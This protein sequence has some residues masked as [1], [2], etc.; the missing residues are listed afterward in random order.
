MDG[1]GGYGCSYRRNALEKC[2]GAQEL[3]RHIHHAAQT[4]V[5]EY[6]LD[7]YALC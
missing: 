1:L 3:F 2:V 4:S 5:L 7:E 6:P